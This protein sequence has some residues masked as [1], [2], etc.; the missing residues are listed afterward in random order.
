MLFCSLG[1][2]KLYF[3]FFIENSC[4][5]KCFK[6][7]YRKNMEKILKELHKFVKILGKM[8]FKVFCG[9][10]VGTTMATDRTGGPRTADTSGGSR[11]SPWS[12]LL[13]GRSHRTV[14]LY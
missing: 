13:S 2:L 5:R 12:W 8:I 4:D 1:T 10:L 14:K 9:F 11:T 6:N 3:G 7:G